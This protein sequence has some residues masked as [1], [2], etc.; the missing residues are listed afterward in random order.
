L[1]VLDA[2]A[3]GEGWGGY[4]DGDQ[5]RWDRIVVSGLSQGAGMAAYI[6]REHT[7]HRVVL[8]SSP[9]DFTGRI[10]QGQLARWIDGTGAT[11]PARWWAEYHRRENTADVL[12]VS[13]A[14]LGIPVD[15]V[16]A[17]DRGLPPNIAPGGQNPFHGSTVRNTDYL[18]QWRTLYGQASDPVE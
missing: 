14:K 9:W 13:Y 5:P 6:A 11:P 3:P 15:H 4:L 2:S 8:F 12:K 16:L 7:V 17:F 10:A 1:R 18:P